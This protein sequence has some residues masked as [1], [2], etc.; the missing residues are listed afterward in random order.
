MDLWE[1]AKTVGGGAWL[2]EDHGVLPW[3]VNLLAPSWTSLSPSLA[4]AMS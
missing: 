1:L 2:E 4:H 3:K